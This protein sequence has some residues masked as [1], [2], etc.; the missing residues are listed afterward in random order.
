MDGRR[1]VNTYRPPTIKPIKGNPKPFLKYM[2]HLIPNATDR[3]EMLRWCA[4]LMARPDIKMLYGILLISTTQGVG[5]STLGEAILSPIVGMWNVS[6]PTEKEI[7]E[8]LFQRLD[9]SQAAGHHPRDI[10]RTLIGGL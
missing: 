9:C 5:K 8:S 4:T 10:C 7:V 1:V 3:I 6:V 2:R